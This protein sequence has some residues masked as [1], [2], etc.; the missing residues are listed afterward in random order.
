MA[1]SEIYKICE[2]MERSAKREIA[3]FRSSQGLPQSS[4]QVS[5]ATKRQT[6][7][8]KSDNNASQEVTVEMKKDLCNRI[9]KLPAEQLTK[10]V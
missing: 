1:G 3:K 2:R 8:V 6:V 10:F 4:N 7:A 5:S 9:K